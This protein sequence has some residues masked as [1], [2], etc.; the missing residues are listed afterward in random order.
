MAAIWRSE[1]RAEAIFQYTALFR[2]PHFPPASRAVAR[3]AEAPASQAPAVSQFSFAALYASSCHWTSH[4]R[5]RPQSSQVKLI[6]FPRTA[7]YEP[8]CYS[9]PGVKKVLVP[10]PPFFRLYL[11]S[12]AAFLYIINHREVTWVSPWVCSNCII[13]LTD[14][15][16]PA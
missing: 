8:P 11:E 10:I 4:R 3:S 2:F 6:I 5:Q 1:K 7:L 13:E 9:P 16:E 14:H 15:M 12:L